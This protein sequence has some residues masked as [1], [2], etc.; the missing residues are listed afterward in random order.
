MAQ[1]P[2]IEQCSRFQRTVCTELGEAIP[3]IQVGQVGQRTQ[4]FELEP[5]IHPGRGL[6]RHFSPSLIQSVH[7]VY[8]PGQQHVQDQAKPEILA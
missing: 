7:Q 4:G 6:L 2:S 8:I 5:D 3:W 1:A